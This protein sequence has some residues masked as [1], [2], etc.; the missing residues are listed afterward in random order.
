MSPSTSTPGTLK[1]GQGCCWEPIWCEAGAHQLPLVFSHISLTLWVWAPVSTVGQIIW[2]LNLETSTP[3]IDFLWSRRS[4]VAR[5]RIWRRRAGNPCLAGEAWPVPGFSFCLLAA[6]PCLALAGSDPG[7]ARNVLAHHPHP[8]PCPIK[9]SPIA[10]KPNLFFA[11][12]SNI[13]NP[14]SA[15]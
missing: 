5:E 3:T 4:F 15:Y 12:F 11:I 9:I 8:T 14:N 2:D 1:T 7:T 13:R 10:A 6:F